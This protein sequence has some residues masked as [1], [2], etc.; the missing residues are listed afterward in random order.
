MDSQT[1]NANNLPPPYYY[2]DMASVLPV[3]VGANRRDAGIPEPRR[4]TREDSHSSPN[5]NLR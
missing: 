1:Q 2:P 4:R 5:K 3:R